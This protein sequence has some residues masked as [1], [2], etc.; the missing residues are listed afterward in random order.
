MQVWPG[1]VEKSVPRSLTE[2]WS[3]R[4]SVSSENT[5]TSELDCRVRTQ[6]IERL[7]GASLEDRGPRGGSGSQHMELGNRTRTPL[8]GKEYKSGLCARKL[9]GPGRGKPEAWTDAEPLAW[10]PRPP[11]PAEPK[12][13]W[14]H[15][16]L[17]RWLAELAGAQLR[18]AHYGSP[19]GRWTPDPGL[20][21]PE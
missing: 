14:A 16:P 9:V 7:R 15:G 21:N 8:L 18:A 19:Y 13:W 17:P 3:R 12:H 5:T 4:E 20:I 10:G 1:L 6:V 11:T 2:V